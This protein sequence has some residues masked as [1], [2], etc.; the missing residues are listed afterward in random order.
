LTEQETYV[1]EIS[2]NHQATFEF[3]EV[4]KVCFYL[5]L[6]EYEWNIRKV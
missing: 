6:I 4:K 2:K 5:S 1:I 3:E